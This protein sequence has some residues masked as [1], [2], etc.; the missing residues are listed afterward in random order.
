MKILYVE[1]NAVNLSLI[2]RIAQ[3]NNHSL[4]SYEEAE[5]ALVE[6]EKGLDIDLILLD[7]QLAGE[8][9]G[10]DFARTVR[11][12]GWKQPIIAITAYAMIGDRERIIEAGCNEYL[13]KPLPIAEFLTLLAKYDPVFTGGA[14]KE[15]PAVV[16]ATPTPAA[17]NTSTQE[18][19]ATLAEPAPPK[20]STQPAKPLIGP[21]EMFPASPATIA[22]AQEALSTPAAEPG[23]PVKGNT[24]PVKTIETPEASEPIQPA[25]P[26]T[27]EP[28]APVQ[29]APP[30][31]SN[32]TTEASSD[33]S[34]PRPLSELLT[35]S[36]AS[37]PVPPPVSDESK[38]S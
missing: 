31:N 29:A 27:E 23:A 33:A 28:A 37:V 32:P 36:E 1:D 24:Q 13:P 12:R 14:A 7:I 35:N 25:V 3:M 30:N 34:K 5:V 38:P 26:Q 2:E 10:I 21:D 16:V 9:D 22:A 15:D 17:A 20:G 4:V 8:M 6:L 18:S 19:A 11:Q